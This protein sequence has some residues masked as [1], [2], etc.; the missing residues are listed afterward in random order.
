MNYISL[1]LEW[2]QA[3]AQK[4]L[5]VQ[6]RL[7]CRLRGEVIQI[8]AVKLDEDLN[9]IGSYRITVK[10]KFFKVIQRYVMRLTGIDQTMLDHGTPLP[11]AIERF[12]RWCGEDFAFLTW[13]PDDIPMLED[14]LRA[15]RLDGSWLHRV[16]DLQLIFNRQTDGSKNQRSLEYAMEHFG[17]EQNLPAHDALNDAY[18]TALVA[19]RLDVAAGIAQYDERRGDNLL[20]TVI[21]DAD[22][23]EKGFSTPEL[24]LADER[25]ATPTCPLCSAPLTPLDNLL[26]SKGQRYTRLFS[27][28]E[29][30]KLF[31][32][33]HLLRNFN[34]TWRAKYV[35]LPAD[36]AGEKDYRKRLQDSAVAT[37]R[38]RR[39]RRKPRQAQEA[40][41][42]G[43]DAA[44]PSPQ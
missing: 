15:H 11:E 9:L 33:M 44:T 7:E 26:H 4:A 39:P 32:R 43:S 35:I 22:G 28:K 13:G 20:T 5:A 16:Y 25:V 19:Q 8:G 30:G 38:R 21:G 29:H 2:N 40:S 24:L 23:G 18:F 34:E 31:L 6:K 17:I 12:H 36:E 3:Y 14:N 10:P 37:T 41:T 42:Q 27:C 1:D